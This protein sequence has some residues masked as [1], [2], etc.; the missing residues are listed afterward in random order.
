MLRAPVPPVPRCVLFSRFVLSTLCALLWPLVATG[1]DTRRVID[2]GYDAAGHTEEVGTVVGDGGPEIVSV[3]P[4]QWWQG[5]EVAV[6]LTGLH[7]HAGRLSLEGSGVYL[8]GVDARD[9]RVVFR[10]RVEEGADVGSRQLS[11][12][13]TL[14]VASV[15]VE[16]RPL[17]PSL[18]VGPSL[19]GLE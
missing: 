17:R 8:S 19:A 16:I 15:S 9:A 4:S 13:T 14:G 3:E 6:R 7:L 2:Y 18:R 11:V 1:A 5:E 10:A 12:T